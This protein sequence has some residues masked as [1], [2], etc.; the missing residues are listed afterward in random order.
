VRTALLSFASNDAIS[1]RMVV[2]TGTGVGTPQI[3]VFP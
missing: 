2:I 1:P 3:A